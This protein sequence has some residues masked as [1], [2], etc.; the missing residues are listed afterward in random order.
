MTRYALAR[1]TAGNGL[2]YVAAT[3]EPVGSGVVFT[4]LRNDA[5]TYVTFDKAIQVCRALHRN[6]YP[7]L[8]VVPVEEA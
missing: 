3:Y 4:A 8:L 7:D 6:S 5:G 2:Q 1:E